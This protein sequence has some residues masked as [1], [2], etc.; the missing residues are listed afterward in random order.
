MNVEVS[1]TRLSQLKAEPVRGAIG[2]AEQA[3]SLGLNRWI[4]MLVF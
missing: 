4:R 3:R 2:A 1:N